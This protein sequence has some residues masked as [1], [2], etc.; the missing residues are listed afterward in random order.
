MADSN[1]VETRVGQ[2]PIHSI[3]MGMPTSDGSKPQ[4]KTT[5]AEGATAEFDDDG[6]KVGGHGGILGGEGFW[7]NV[8]GVSEAFIVNGGRGWMER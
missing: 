4:V 1:D 7:C 5:T 2:A 3:E 6:V 8:G